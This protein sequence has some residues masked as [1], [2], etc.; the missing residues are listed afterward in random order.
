[1]AAKVSKVELWMGKRQLWS[2]EWEQ[3]VSDAHRLLV[4]FLYFQNDLD[5]LT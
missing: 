3:W 5:T 4:L 1:M 2:R